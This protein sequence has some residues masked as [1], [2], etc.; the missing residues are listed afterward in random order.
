MESTDVEKH[1][2]SALKA[3]GNDAPTM[4]KPLETI[5]RRADTTALDAR[6]DKAL[7]ELR[8]SGSA[9]ALKL[10][11]T[12]GQG[13][14]GVVQIA[15]QTSVGRRVAVKKLRPEFKTR[16]AT[17]KLLREAWVIG[18]LEHP[19]ILPIH[20]VRLDEEGEPQ[21]VLK[22][23]EGVAWGDVIRD[24]NAMRVRFGAEDLLEH[25]LQ[26]LMQV[27]RAVHFAHSRGIVHRDIKPSNVMIGTHGEVYLLDWGIAVSLREDPEKRLPLASDSVE[28]TGTPGYMAPELLQC[29]L[30]TERTDVYLLGAVLFEI[31]SG[32]PPHRGD[33]ARDVVVSVIRSTP[34]LP[35]TVPAELADIALRAM[36]Q[37]PDDRFASAEELRL[38]LVRHLQQKTAVRLAEEAER[39][40]DA[41]HDLTKDPA[42]VTRRALAYGLYGGCCFGY[43]EALE[44]RPDYPL[45]KKGIQRAVEAMIELELA[46][47]EPAAASELLGELADPPL[48]LSLRVDDALAA[49]LREQKRIASLVAAGEDRDAARGARMRRLLVGAIGLSWTVVPLVTAWIVDPKKGDYPPMVVAP[50]VVLGLLGLIAWLGRDELRKTAINR[51]VV[52]MLAVGLVAQLALA[53][54]TPLL[55]LNGVNARAFVLFLWAIVVGGC[56]VM[57]DRRL[58]WGAFAALIAFGATAVFATTVAHTLYAMA[59]TYFV[60]SIN[61]LAIW[62]PA[63][64]SPETPPPSAKGTREP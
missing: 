33:T 51:G 31:L 53:L 3:L 29:G 19:N 64:V 52:G 46:W 21:I 54:A 17:L 36:A 43:R 25:N 49:S 5:G 47:G 27:C 61:A 40:L 10:E 48:P 15:V 26:V 32:E 4:L 44:I 7:A 55:G 12:I 1:V 37:D 18:S 23:I 16:E 45:A 39:R 42:A 58:L 28:I 60:M 63:P 9:D 11:G 30:I 8:A 57:I 2:Q 38:A 35:D 22:R 6:V 13:G 20:D 14:M 56:G 34:E 62:R 41:L 24:E 50:L 59:A